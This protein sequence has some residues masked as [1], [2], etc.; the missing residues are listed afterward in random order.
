MRIMINGSQIRF[1]YLDELKDL[2]DMGKSTI[3]RASHVE[4]IET[5]GQ[6]MWQADIS[7][8]GGPKLGPFPLRKDA[9]DA[10]IK[11]IEEHG[12]GKENS[13]VQ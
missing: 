2:L 6:I 8:I 7:P 9:L 11:W 10:E 4:P 13:N 12:L 5:D 1:V 3:K